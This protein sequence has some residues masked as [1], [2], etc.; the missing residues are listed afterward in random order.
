MPK[1]LRKILLIVTIMVCSYLTL[2]AVIHYSRIL[3]ETDSEAT[4]Y[5]S[6]K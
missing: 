1:H 3:A 4:A 5:P 6:V 2:M